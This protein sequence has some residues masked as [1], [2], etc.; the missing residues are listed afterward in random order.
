[1]GIYYT[2]GI[3]YVNNMKA[4]TLLIVMPSLHLGG[5][6]SHIAQI[7]PGLKEKGWQITVFLT[8]GSGELTNLLATK[9]ITIIRANWLSNQLHN[10]SKLLRAPL[11]VLTFL[12]LT[13]YLIR[14][15]PT[16]V[17]FMLPEAY[18]IGGLSCIVTGQ[19]NLFMSRRSLNNYQQKYPLLSKFEKW[20]H[21]KMRGII[22]NS[23]ANIEQL[24]KDEQVQL[25][26]LQLIY[27]GI[28]VNRFNNLTDNNASIRQQFNLPNSALT[29]IVV[30]NV[31][32]YKGHATLLAALATI[33]E[34]LPSD[35]QLLCVGRKHDY[36]RELETLANNLDIA[37]HIHWLGTQTN[38]EPLLAISD[39]AISSSYEEGF[40]NA[41]IE[42]MAA[43]LPLVVTNVGG[44]PE[45]VV[46]GNTG[47]VVPARDAEALAA[48]ILRLSVQPA[49][50]AAMGAA[51]MQRVTE[52]FSLA[53]CVN[54]YDSIYSE[55]L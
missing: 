16:V 41:V 30:A 54:A 8:S 47:L 25:E 21:S 14:A 55:C 53:A 52:Q 13:L 32:P 20:L 46:D 17:Q 22:T 9:G 24:N 45:A 7:L 31:I 28:D 19:Q 33:A 43:G 1:M 3:W 36:V 23:Q 2:L 44:N 26:K 42:A 15:K 6:E 27:N 29:L 10:K 50:R 48:A 11:L 49:T 39:I 35:W 5:T 4:K 38:V 34:Q 51:G 18:L 40:S 37:Q 12:Q